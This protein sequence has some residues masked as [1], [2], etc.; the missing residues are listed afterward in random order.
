MQFFNLDDIYKKLNRLYDKGNI[1]KEYINSTDIFL[2]EVKLKN[3]QQKHIQ[4]NYLTFAKELANLKNTNLPILYKEYNFK[5]LGVQ[6]LPYSIKIDS[7]DIFLNLIDKTKEYQCFISNYEKVICK[8]FKLKDT[9]F[10]KPFL[11]IEYKDDWDKFFLII[12]FFLL[13]KQQNSYIR[14]ISLKN[15]D[16]KYIEKHKKIIDILISAIKNKN[17]LES[18]K[19]FSFEKKYDLKYILPQVRFRILDTD[20][21]IGDL[22]DVTLN[23]DE[24]EKL[25]INCKKVYIVEN[26]ITTLAFPNTKDS[27]VI[28]GSGYKVG[29]LKNTKWLQDKDIFYW[30]DIDSDGFAILSQ[31]RG[32]FSHI[33]SIFMDKETFYKFNNFIVEYQKTNIDKILDN[34]TKDELQLYKTINTQ[35]LEQER[36]PYTYIQNLG[37]K[38]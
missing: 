38:L 37:E 17:S 26:K 5:T 18:I 25:K 4:E 3:I 1:F 16:T 13:N 31:I 12:E 27:I 32:Y 20:L 7:L 34:L 8:Y 2:I 14:E 30:G 6:K 19:D 29:V 33:K 10:N 23:I 35:R 11:T 21:Y 36:L 9:I 15:I 24:F 28:F 22:S